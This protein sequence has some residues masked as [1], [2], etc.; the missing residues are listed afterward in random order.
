M[1][2]RSGYY[3]FRGCGGENLFRFFGWSF[4]LFFPSS[5]LPLEKEKETRTKKTRKTQSNKRGL[6]LRVRTYL[7]VGKKSWVVYDR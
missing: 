4:F 7:C 2:L 5:S 3:S 1:C 6:L